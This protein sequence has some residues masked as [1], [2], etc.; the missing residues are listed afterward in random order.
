MARNSLDGQIPAF[1]GLGAHLLRVALALG[2]AILL[3]ACDYVQEKFIDHK[4]KELAKEQVLTDKDSIHVILCGTGSPQQPDRSRVQACTLVAAGGHLFLFDAGEGATL[5]LQA[6]RVSTAGIDKVFI[7]HWHSDHFN[8]LGGLINH[9]WIMGRTTPL[10]VYGPPGANQVVQGLKEAYEKDVGFRSGHMKTRP[11][12]AYAEAQE[13]NLPAGQDTVRVFE[14]DGVTIDAHRVVHVEPSYGYVIRYRGKKVFVSGDTRVDPVYMPAMEHADVAVH[15]AV[16]SDLVTQSAR[17][18]RRNG[19]DIRALIAERIISYHADTLELAR[20]AQKAGV[21]H[22]VLTHLIPAPDSFAAK[23]LFT[24]GMK[25][26][27]GGEITLGEDGTHIVLP[28]DAAATGT[29]SA[30]AQRP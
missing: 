4:V 2:C 16:Q 3:P 28:V 18:M 17:A 24:A 6:L 13:I 12:L 20:M 11:E 25:D 14:Q 30:G 21:K 27:F 23:Q 10:T 26:L 5:S 7:T 22:L 8:D 19:M 29:A 9:G 1:A 15:E